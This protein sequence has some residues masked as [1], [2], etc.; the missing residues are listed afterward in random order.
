M[1]LPSFSLLADRTPPAREYQVHNGPLRQI[2]SE[3]LPL[4]VRVEHGSTGTASD[5]LGDASA[6]QVGVWAP[7]TTDPEPSR[8]PRSRSEHLRRVV[9]PRQ[10]KGVQA[11]SRTASFLG[12]AASGPQT[13]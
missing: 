7:S 9:S 8:P 2:E 10:E 13:C 3:E 12:G 1:S 5:A 6:R 4:F 11:P